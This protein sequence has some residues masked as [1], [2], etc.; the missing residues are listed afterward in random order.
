MLYYKIIDGQEVISQCRT[1]KINGRWVSN[2]TEEMILADGWLP[3]TPPPVIP[4]PQEEPD[5]DQVLQSVKRMLSTQTDA[6][7]DEE[8]LEVAALYPTWRSKIGETVTV[9]T[10]LWDD[11]KLWKVILPHT[12]Q[13]DWR[14]ADAVSLYVEV[15]I[16][17]WPL[18][19]Q[20]I[21]AETAY[22]LNAQVSWNDGH[23]ISEVDNNTWEP[24][25]YGWR[26]V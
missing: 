17:E 1:L 22:K 23:W 7:S 24:G 25:V 16:E 3:Y 12:V 6:L 9:G 11:G 15:S 8:A 26:R 5:Y 20:P 4:T 2:P 13:E 10:R 19:V 21:S 14:P 18:W